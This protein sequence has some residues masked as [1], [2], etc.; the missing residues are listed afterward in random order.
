MGYGDGSCGGGGGGDEK[1]ANVEVLTVV[2][3]NV[4]R[5]RVLSL[6]D[7]YTMPKHVYFFPESFFFNGAVFLLFSSKYPMLASITSI[8][9]IRH[10]MRSLKLLLN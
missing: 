10:L 9:Y 1:C 7:R 4:G 3:K 8:Y 2:W 5:D 6:G